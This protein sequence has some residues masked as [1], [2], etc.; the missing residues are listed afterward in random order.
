MVVKL[1]PKP[2]TVSR[3]DAERIWSELAGAEDD[4]DAVPQSRFVV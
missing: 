3:Q 4:I 1:S 2:Y